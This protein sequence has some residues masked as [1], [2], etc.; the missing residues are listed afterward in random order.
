MITVQDL[1]TWGS[2]YA[3]ETDKLINFNVINT[4]FSVAFNRDF[5]TI[6]SSLM[7]FPQNQFTDILSILSIVDALISYN[8]TEIPERQVVSTFDMI[9][10]LDD[11]DKL[12]SKK[13]ARIR[14]VRV[15]DK[16]YYDLLV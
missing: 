4:Q 12:L 5:G 14:Y 9:D 16:T 11:E 13:N 15:A 7:N 3:K 8:E 10:L 6:L 2:D 1:E